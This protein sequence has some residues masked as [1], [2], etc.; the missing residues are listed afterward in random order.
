MCVYMRLCTHSCLHGRY[1]TRCTPLRLR[2]K[3]PG[4]PV[5]V[6]LSVYEGFQTQGFTD[7]PPLA[8][9]VVERWYLAPGVRRV[10]LT[11]GGVTGTL[12]L[13]PGRGLMMMMDR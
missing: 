4:T 9:S 13:P 3:V 10:E 6:T 7:G 5:V 8:S 11:E 2:K 1:N 12:F